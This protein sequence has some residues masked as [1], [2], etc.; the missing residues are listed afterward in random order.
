MDK[1]S[2][3][4]KIERFIN[5]NSLMNEKN[6]YLV[7]LSGGADSVALL[8]SLK[9]L[10]Y[11]VEAV[12]C[13]FHLRGEE[14]DHDEQFCIELCKS[15][16]IKIHIVHFNT[17]EYAKLHKVSIE[18][19][20]RNLR[21][22]YFENLRKDINAK[23]ICIG[24]HR[25]DSVETLLINLIRGT[26][27]NGMTGIAAKNGVILRPMLD[28][29][30]N[31]IEDYLK[32]VGQD[33]VVD[34]T[35]LE[36]DVTRNKIR[37]N[38]MPIIRKINPSADKDISATARRI[39]EAA[40]VFNEAIE[41]SSDIV[42]EKSGNCTTID[43]E[44][45]QKET[46]PEYTLYNIL[47]K[48]SF[49]SSTIENI[50]DKLGIMQ[51]G[52]VFTSSTHKLLID[53]NKIIIEQICDRKEK[54]MKIPECGTYKFNDKLKFRFSEHEIDSEYRIEKNKNT[55]TIDEALTA[56]PLMIR[57]ITTGD[58]FIPFGMKGKK[59]ISDFLTDKK[60]SVFDKERQLVVTDAQNNILWIAGE[61]S[62]NR[63]RV[64][65]RTKKVIKIELIKE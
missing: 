36:D 46:S 27:I 51:T 53:R 7:A 26:G 1:K 56:F 64:T 17:L 30:R 35:N 3:L 62:D 23:G 25:E 24:H 14:S 6:L 54:D 2:F 12:H 37:L 8:L 28:I 61:R 45:L 59:L 15:R 31:D 55:A 38:L 21:Y 40:K 43:I 16:N 20:A 39:S 49:T 10:G 18:M 41:R 9:E 4:N 48:F 58:W 34:S 44:K 65:S 50:H 32:T 57:H 13:N 60:F 22:S 5:S 42:T 11:K 63:F 47:S 29:S 52:K 19:A 33:F